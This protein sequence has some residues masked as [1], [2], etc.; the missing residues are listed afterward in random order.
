MLSYC[1]DETTDGRVPA[2]AAAM[3]K[4]ASGEDADSVLDALAASGFVTPMDD[5]A[6]YLPSWADY[7][8]AREDVEERRRLAAFA[9]KRGGRTRATTGP[10]ATD[11]RFK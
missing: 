1:A 9:G 8:L 11:G 5:G 4:A 7:N 2:G 10:R 3:L 6:I